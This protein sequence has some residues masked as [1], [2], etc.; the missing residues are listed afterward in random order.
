MAGLQQDGSLLL[1]V[2]GEATAAGAASPKA[3]ASGAPVVSRARGLS[4]PAAERLGGERER[5]AARGGRRMGGVS[6][7]PMAME[8]RC[9]WP[10]YL[11][12]GTCVGDRVQTRHHGHRTSFSL[13]ERTWRRHL[14]AAASWP[15]A[16]LSV[17]RSHEYIRRRSSRLRLDHTPAR[18]PSCLL[19]SSHSRGEVGAGSRGVASP[20]RIIRMRLLAAACC[21]CAT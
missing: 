18:T 3:M 13:S 17:P 4:S 1:G 7:T 12:T 16:L 11:R 14:D 8:I 20:K 21:L 15:S 6:R 2:V 9:G 19:A 5:E 10:K